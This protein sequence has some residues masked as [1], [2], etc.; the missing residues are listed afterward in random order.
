MI[1]N[2]LSKA[3]YQQRTT[4]LQTQSNQSTLAEAVNQSNYLTKEKK[5]KHIH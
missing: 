2:N 1:A 3:Y 4:K 5:G